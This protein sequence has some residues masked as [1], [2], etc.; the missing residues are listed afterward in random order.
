MFVHLFITLFQLTTLTVL[1]SLAF[2]HLHHLRVCGAG[3][4]AGAQGPDGAQNEADGDDGGGAVHR[5]DARV[6]K[7]TL[8][9]F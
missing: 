1:I 6:K 5:G 4:G 7:S 2:A 3:A 9:F 8:L